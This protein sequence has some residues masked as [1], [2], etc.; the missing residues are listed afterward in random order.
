MS[1]SV[2]VKSISLA[3]LTLF[4]FRFSPY[5]SVKSDIL[6]LYLRVYC[7]SQS[8]AYAFNLTDDFSLLIAVSCDASI[9]ST[10]LLETP[11]TGIN[12]SVTA[13]EVAALK[14]S[15]QETQIFINNEKVSAALN[16]VEKHIQQENRKIDL[17]LMTYVCKY[18]KA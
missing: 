1:R 13:T 3:R 10:F 11:I 2:M 5:T 14:I 15:S 17:G 4:S 6:M 18:L 7:W 9:L 12:K 16:V 8:F